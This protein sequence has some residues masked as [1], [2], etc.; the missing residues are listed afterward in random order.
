MVPFRVE[1]EAVRI[2]P[3]RTKPHLVALALPAGASEASLTA[4]RVR[5]GCV[6]AES[7]DVT[8]IYFERT[9][10]NICENDSHTNISG[11]AEQTTLA[12]L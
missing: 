10:V 6:V 8:V 11:G 2:A 12:R 7:V 9:L 3:A 1:A 4:T 5:A